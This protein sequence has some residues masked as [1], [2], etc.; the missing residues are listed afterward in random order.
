MMSFYTTVAAICAATALTGTAAQA[1]EVTLRVH[2]FMHATS[3][4]HVDFIEPWC[5]K[6]K[7]ESEGRMA[8]QIFPSMQLGGSPAELLGQLN[9]GIADLVFANPGYAPGKYLKSEVFELP[10]MVQDV[11]QG[12]Q[13][14]W[15]FLEMYGEDELPGVKIIATT[16]A[17]YTLIM[18]TDKSIHTLDDMKGVKLR[19]SSRYASKTLEALGGLPVQ[20]PGPQITESM[21]RG[22]TDGGLLPWSAV[23]LLQ[24]SDLAKHFTDFGDDQVKLSNAAQIFGMSQASYDKLPD[25]LKAVIDNNSGLGPSVDFAEVYR[26][27]MNEDRDIIAASDAEIIILPDDEYQRW[28]EAT[29]GVKDEWISDANAKG[30]DGAMLLSEAERLLEKYKP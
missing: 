22:V 16:P 2:S 20:V 30:L 7:A 11:A 1:Q 14:M 27:K 5:E 8:C 26:T 13:A 10:F 18:T 4:Q 29:A 17:D 9:D 25:D 23:R 6:V 19:S 28:V 24:L 3:Y 12:A 15:D 21:M